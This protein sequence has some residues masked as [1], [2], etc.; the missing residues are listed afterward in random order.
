LPTKWWIADKMMDYP[1]TMT[2]FIPALQ[3]CQPAR[4][5]LFPAPMI[6]TSDEI[7]S[8]RYLPILLRVVLREEVLLRAPFP[9]AEF[10]DTPFFA[11]LFRGEL[12]FVALF[13]GA[14][15]FDALFA[16]ALF[17]DALL[18]DALFFDALFFLGTFAPSFLASERPIAIACLGL[19]TFLPL[20]PLLS[21]PSFI[22]RIDLSTLSCD[23]F[24]YFAIKMILMMVKYQNTC[25]IN[26][27]LFPITVSRYFALPH[28]FNSI[29][30]LRQSC[31]QKTASGGSHHIIIFDA[32]PAEIPEGF[33]LIV[34]YK[35]S[36]FLL[37]LPQLH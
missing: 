8:H 18:F 29:G 1:S 2:T 13:A 20:L 22:S 21:S 30:R 3:R 11:A 37:S 33:Q 10:L 7:L 35:L 12:F 31:T 24:E 5:P 23:F 17:F 32:N 15:F 34:L 14:L 25:H 28:G 16:G 36:K 4:V 9:E 19:V 26:F 27:L 6:T